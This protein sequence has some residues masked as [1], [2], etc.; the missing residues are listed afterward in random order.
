[1]PNRLY[2]PTTEEE[3]TRLRW[4]ILSLNVVLHDDDDVVLNWETGKLGS[5]ANAKE[6]KLEITGMD[7]RE[8]ASYRF[9][10]TR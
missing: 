4:T 3:E 5:C 10:E 7:F 1:M 6:R 2:F 8:P 9:C